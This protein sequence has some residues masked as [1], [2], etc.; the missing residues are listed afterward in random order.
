MFQ[1]NIFINVLVRIFGYK[2]D[3]DLNAQPKEF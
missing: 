1:L 3:H 2:Y